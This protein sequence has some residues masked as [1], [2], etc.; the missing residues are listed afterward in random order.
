[1]HARPKTGIATNLPLCLT[2][3]HN[4]S[5][6]FKSA[7]FILIISDSHKNSSYNIG[8]KEA[9]SCLTLRISFPGQMKQ[10][11]TR[12][13]ILTSQRSWKNLNGTSADS[14]NHFA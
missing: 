14:T 4:T 7:A 6:D 2:E 3:A 11:K 1:M 5:F 8:G 13:D 10:K 12:E 9:V